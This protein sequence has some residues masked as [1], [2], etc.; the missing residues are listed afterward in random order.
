[1]VSADGAMRLYDL[2]NKDGDYYE[3]NRLRFLDAIERHGDA[4]KNLPALLLLGSMFGAE[5]END[6]YLNRLRAAGLR[7][8]DFRD[9]RHLGHDCEGMTNAS[10]PE[11]M[12]TFYNAVGAFAPWRPS[13]SPRGPIQAAPFDV[14]VRLAEADWTIRYTL[15]GSDPHQD[16]RT[17]RGPIHLDSSCWLRVIGVS[18]D[19]KNQSR[20]T[21]VRYTIQAPLP[22]TPPGKKSGLM[23]RAYEGTPGKNLE[24]FLADI[25]KG[26]KKPTAEV[27]VTALGETAAVLEK[28]TDRIG[29]LTYS[30]ALSVPETGVYEFEMAW[31]GGLFFPQAG[32]PL[33]TVG[34]KS[35]GI[36]TVT[37]P[38]E[39][40]SHPILLLQ[41]V[42]DAG[43]G[44]TPLRLRVRQTEESFKPVPSTWFHE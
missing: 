18:P 43:S 42:T 27:A 14:T 44:N 32:K 9:C 21:L 40:G 36:G 25:Q 34:R 17:A 30:G 35:P 11:V 2:G 16:G 20:E 38:L 23:L 24:R 31:R 39:K 12:A 41:T 37:V 4:A 1:V 8:L 28:S 3:R 7:D 19:G 33:D 5:G 26:V 10:F 29:T 13:L 6:P 15:D 22:A